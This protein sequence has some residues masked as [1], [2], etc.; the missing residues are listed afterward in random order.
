[1]D[2]QMNEQTNKWRE[3]REKEAKV[4]KWKDQ[5]LVMV[6][7]YIYIYKYVYMNV[8]VECTLAE[9]AQCRG[10]RAKYT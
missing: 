1:M 8:G 6:D 3:R 2:E 4:D 9:S 10:S 7:I 5:L